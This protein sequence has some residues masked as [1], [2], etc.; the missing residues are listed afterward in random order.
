MFSSKSI[1]DKPNARE[2]LLPLDARMW[3][4]LNE[5]SLNG[6]EIFKENEDK[7]KIAPKS[8]TVDNFGSK[9]DL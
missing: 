6:H 3:R 2:I 4:K 7:R 9:G 1:T 8:L 5:S